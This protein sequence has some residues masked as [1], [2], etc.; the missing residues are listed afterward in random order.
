MNFS[1]P[2][3]LTMESEK[4][5]KDLFDSHGDELDS[6]LKIERRVKNRGRR[7]DDR[8]RPSLIKRL[9]KKD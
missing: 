1:V 2:V 3:N 8:D 5:I 7:M 9:F 6:G 4:K